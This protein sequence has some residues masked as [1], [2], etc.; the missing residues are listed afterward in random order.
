ME[1]PA[2]SIALRM[3]ICA[4]PFAPPPLSVSPILGLL[5]TTES[6]AA[7]GTLKIKNRQ[8]D[9]NR[10]RIKII[11]ESFLINLMVYIKLNKDPEMQFS[12]FQI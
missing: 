9:I 6:C 4:R 3:P 8:Q 10:V 2:E 11:N 12:N 7:E 5:C 1:S